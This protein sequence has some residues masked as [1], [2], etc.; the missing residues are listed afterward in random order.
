MISN[1]FIDFGKKRNM[2]VSTSINGSSLSPRIAISRR[3]P[4]RHTSGH[5]ASTP[6]PP[7]SPTLSAKFRTHS[8]HRRPT[9]SSILC[10]PPFPLLNTWPRQ[11][12]AMDADGIQPVMTRNTKHRNTKHRLDRIIHTDH[13]ALRLRLSPSNERT[14][15]AVIRFKFLSIG[16][17]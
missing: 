9:E 6:T 10:K 17:R 5:S 2:V 7:P 14:Q 1:V 15:L 11:P 16:Q 4:T 13:S 3:H 8:H 12:P